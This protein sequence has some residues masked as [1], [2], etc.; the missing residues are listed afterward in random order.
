MGE[1]GQS[2]G[3]KVHHNVHIVDFLVQIA[4]CKDYNDNVSQGQE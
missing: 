1:C 4:C 2:H 3:D